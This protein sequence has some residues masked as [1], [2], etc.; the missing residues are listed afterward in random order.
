[1]P[2]QA[3]N[4]SHRLIGIF[5]GTFD[6]IHYGH[7]NAVN[8]LH[9]KLKFER[10]HWVLSA[11]PP[12]KDGTNASVTQR[13][14]MLKL[15][16]SEIPDNFADDCEIRRDQKSY[17]IDTVEHFRK[18]YPEHRL[19][20]IIGG[21]SFMNLPSWHRY[22]ELLEM[23]HIVVMARPGYTLENNELFKIA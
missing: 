22:T 12:H 6:P 16:L 11:R 13:F 9:R 5:G 7:I 23:V 3:Q 18:L 15:A 8:Q 1:M 4:V 21:D 20:L 2:K 14:E 17:T 19:C 10:V